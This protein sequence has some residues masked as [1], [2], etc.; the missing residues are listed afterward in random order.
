MVRRA[1][2]A[3]KSRKGDA[4]RG[5]DALCRR[6]RAVYGIRLSWARLMVVRRPAN[7]SL[8]D[9]L[10]GQSVY[11]RTVVNSP[12]RQPIR[13]PRRAR[14]APRSGRGANARACRRNGRPLRATTPRAASTPRQRP[15]RKPGV[16]ARSSRASRASRCPIRSRRALVRCG[17]WSAS[18]AAGRCARSRARPTVPGGVHR[19]VCL[20]WALPFVHISA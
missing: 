12:Q 1:V 5:L 11:D 16:A 13:R 15:E 2:P 14:A 3:S 19:R 4:Q 7:L 6:A 17:G 18:P 9:D 8:V 10:G 20:I